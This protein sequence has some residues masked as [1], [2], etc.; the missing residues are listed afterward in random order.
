VEIK[1]EIIGGV[2][3]LQG[4]PS[5]WPCT[6]SFVIACSVCYVNLLIGPLTRR[7]IATT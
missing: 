7:R 1:K 4:L 3:S 6:L 2:F 5:G